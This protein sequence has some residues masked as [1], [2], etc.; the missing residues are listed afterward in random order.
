MEKIGDE[1]IQ[2]RE[3]ENFNQEA[4]KAYLQQH[5]SVPDKPMEVKQFST[6]SS[7]LTYFIK[8][9]DWEAVLRRPP[10]GPLPPKAHDMK[11]ES[12]LL[13][14]LYP[15]FNLVPKPYIYCEDDSIIGAPFYVMERKTGVVVDKGFPADFEY[16]EEIGKNISEAM[17]DTL[18]K[19][20]DVDYKKADLESF[21]YPD[22]F[23]ERQVNSWIKRYL[24]TK[25][26]DSPHFERVSKWIVDNMPKS[27]YVSVIHNDY[28]INNTLLSP[29][30]KK[31]NAVF[32]WE[33][34]T[35][36]DP[37]FDLGVTL[38]Y[39][40]Q[41]DDPDYIKITMPTVTHYPGFYSRREFIQAYSQK[42]GRDTDDI[43]YYIVFSYFKLA[44]VF[45][46]IYYRYYMGQTNDQRFATYQQRAIEAM[47]FANYLIDNHSY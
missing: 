27:K 35:V 40:V 42:S 14:R 37:L 2:V 28:K 32:D 1:L 45:Q 47:S 16:T 36:A 4:V 29:D 10:F 18:V 38:G 24:N 15:E 33:M 34:A 11:R 46:Q 3:G 43:H 7:N 26:E 20:H 30:Y 5:L 23:V 19:L 6:G 12:E 31:V 41:K 25:T 17:I 22:G 8:L 44:G 39:W 13:T 21:G 9:G